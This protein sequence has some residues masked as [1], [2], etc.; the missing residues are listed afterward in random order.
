MKFG[1]DEFELV[2]IYYNDK[3]RIELNIY[4][5]IKVQFTDGYV[6]HTHTRIRCVSS[7]NVPKKE[8]TFCSVPGVDGSLKLVYYYYGIKPYQTTTGGGKFCSFPQGIKYGTE[9]PKEQ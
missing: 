9:R 4:I 1:L 2:C 6:T 3:L 8:T 7:N 5:T